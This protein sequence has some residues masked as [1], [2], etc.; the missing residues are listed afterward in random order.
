[1]IPRPETEELVELILKENSGADKRVLDIGTGSG[2]IAISLK[3]ARTDWQ[4]TASDISI[5]ALN[6][7]RDNGGNTKS[8]L[9]GCNLMYLAI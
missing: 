6:L 3:A 8:R 2:A 4:V 7:A 1:M 9:I 5:D